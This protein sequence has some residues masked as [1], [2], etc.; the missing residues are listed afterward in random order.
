[1]ID[2]TITKVI[3]V[4][5]KGGLGNQLF[6]YVFGLKWAGYY[7]TDLK[8]DLSWFQTNNAKHTSRPFALNL[9]QLPI[10]EASP[11]DFKRIG[12]PQFRER[13]IVTKA[14]NKVVQAVHPRYIKQQGFTDLYLDTTIPNDS[15]LDGYWISKYPV[16][17]QRSQLRDLLSIRS[18]HLLST[19]C[20][21]EIMNSQSIAVHIRRGDYV[22]T[23]NFL[24]SKSYFLEGINRMKNLVSGNP[25]FYIFTDDPQW[26]KANLNEHL[27][28]KGIRFRYI[29]ELAPRGKHDIYH[30]YLMTCC[31]H[32]IISNSSFSW[33]GAW[34]GDF[35]DKVVICPDQFETT[36]TQHPYLIM[37]GWVPVRAI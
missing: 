35:A 27:K 34:L 1:M 30:F 18:Q 19:D 9:F 33:W 36:N 23:G 32:F 26:C 25:V 21:N 8:V 22:T 7:D 2:A 24:L 6:Q 13:S 12:I 10:S 4:K 11:G 3:I 29:D 17:E 16:E 5:I 28:H 20:F 37:D 15:C 14:L 31:K